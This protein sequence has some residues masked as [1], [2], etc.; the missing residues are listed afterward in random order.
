MLFTQF[1]AVLA[2]FVV[3]PESLDDVLVELL[4]LESLELELVLGELE[5]V[6]LLPPLL[7]APDLLEL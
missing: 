3:E 1:A 4:L 2:A 6:S 5:L 7:P